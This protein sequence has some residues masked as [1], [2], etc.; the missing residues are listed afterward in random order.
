MFI[1]ID[2]EKALD[3]SQRPVMIKIFSKSGL[4]D[5]LNQI[6]GIHEKAVLT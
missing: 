5:L 4:M 1:S 3:K 6:K 2:T